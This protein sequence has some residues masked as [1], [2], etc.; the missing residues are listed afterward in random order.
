M[1]KDVFSPNKTMTRAEFAAIVTRALGLAAKDK[2]FT[3]VPSSKW[4]AGYI[5]A[6]NSSGIVNGVGGGKFNPRRHHHP[7][8]SRGDGRARGKA[9]RAGY[10]DGRSCD[11]KYA[12][13]VWR[14]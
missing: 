10:Y 3:D 1:S 11:Q 9:L 12:G 7:A 14:L 6:A 13:A 4:Y 5:G 8:R 2:V